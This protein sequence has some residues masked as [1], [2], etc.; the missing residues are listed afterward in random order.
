M[1]PGAVPMRCSMGAAPRGTSAWRA[2]LS[3]MARPREENSSAILATIAGSR[4]SGTFMTSAMASRVRS[5]WVGPSPPHTITPSLRA[6]AVRSARTTLDVLSPT[7]WWK[8]E[9]TPASASCSP[10]HAEFVSAIWP[11][12]DS[13]PTATT[14]T[15][16]RRLPRRSSYDS[17]RAPSVRHVLGA[18]HHRE[19]R[20]HPE[21]H[22]QD[23]RVRRHRRRQT[24]EHGHALH[25]GL[26]L[27]RGTRRDRH[28]APAHDDPVQAHAD[29]TG[30]DDRDR[31][32]RNLAPAGQ[33]EQRADDG[34]LVG[35]RVEER[36]RARRA[37]PPRDP[38]VDA[39]GETDGDGHPERRPPRPAHGDHGHEDRGGQ[40]PGDGD[41][42]RRGDERGRPEGGRPGAPTT[43]GAGGVRTVGGA[44]GAGGFGGHVSAHTSGPAAP[45]T[46]PSHSAPTGIERST[47]TTPSIS[48]ASRCE[49]ATPGSSTRTVSRS[50]TSAARRSAVMVSWSSAHSRSRSRASSSG[51]A[52]GRPAAYVP[53]SHDH[54]KNPPQSSCAS[55]TNARSSSW[56]ASVSPGY[57]T[58]N[59]DRSAAS[60]AVARILAMRSKKRAPS[61][62]RLIRRTKPRATCCNDRSKYGT[63]VCT[64]VSMSRSSSD[65]GYRY[66]RRTRGTRSATAP[67]SVTI[68]RSPPPATAPR[69][70][71]L[72]SSPYEARS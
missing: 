56:S 8:C 28:A 14:S 36:S 58:M 67:T 57:P 71:A 27:G 37:L 70:G 60:G 41:A 54:V 48:G 22:L 24:Q 19:R 65:D 52:S 42:V 23:A 21:P 50:P 33:G 53:G 17:R 16:M 63:P 3:G 30:G 1:R 12:S 61:P 4:S 26:H 40:K 39:V 44:G 29:L 10:S 72:R 6:S 13:V 47:C 35:E 46:T 11:R 66:R 34:G 45:V 5:S 15:L 51:T 68:G 7:A 31:Q 59:D 38:P 2:L 18:G 43:P 55:A 64:I 25:E 9:S 69:S 32:P 62:H 49:R 20:R